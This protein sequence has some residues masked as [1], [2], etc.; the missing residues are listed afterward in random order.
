MTTTRQTVAS[1][2]AGG[3]GSKASASQAGGAGGRGGAIGR[4]MLLAALAGSVF[5]TQRVLA[6]QNMITGPVDPRVV[7]GNAAFARQGN[8]LTIT[9]SRLA[10]INYSS[11]NVGAGEYVRFVQPDASSRVMNRITGAEP[12]RIEG[13]I[14][15]NGRVYW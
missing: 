10:I 11:F 5:G 3:V 2:V 14:D 4:A 8:N 7:V 9:T 1:V 12:T 15:A 13:R 6:Q